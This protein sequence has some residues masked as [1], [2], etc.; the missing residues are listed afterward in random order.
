MNFSYAWDKAYGTARVA[1]LDQEVNN[2]TL[3]S[4]EFGSRIRHH[5][6]GHFGD[7]AQ[8]SNGVYPFFS[9]TYNAPNIVKSFLNGGTLQSINSLHPRNNM[10]GDMV[11]SLLGSK[12]NNGIGMASTCRECSLAYYAAN[13]TT[14]VPSHPNEWE[15]QTILNKHHYKALRAS[16]FTGNQIINKSGYF[17]ANNLRGTT[18]Y[19]KCSNQVSDYYGNKQ[20]LCQMLQYAKDF[21]VIFVAS[22]GNGNT[23]SANWPAN[24]KD[25]VIGVGGTDRTAKTW[26]VYR[27]Q[28]TCPQQTSTNIFNGITINLSVNYLECGSQGNHHSIMAPAKDV[29]VYHHNGSYSITPDLINPNKFVN[30]GTGCI[31]LSTTDPGYQTCSG[32][33]FSAPIITGIISIMRSLNP[34]LSFDE[35]RDILENSR[36]Y[37]SDIG[38]RYSIPNI[39]AIMKNDVLGLVGGNRVLNRL[40]PM[41]RLNT[42]FS[43]SGSMKSNYLSTSI[44]QVAAAGMYGNYLAD[45][46]ELTGSLISG[47]NTYNVDANEPLA[48]GYPKFREPNAAIKPNNARAPFYIFGGHEN[49]F[50]G[51][52]DMIPLHHFALKPV[53]S[54]QPQCYDRADHAYGTVK[55]T[56]FGN[57]DIRCNTDDTRYVW[58]GIEGYLLPSCPTGQTCYENSGDADAAQCLMLRYSSADDSYALLMESEL[59]KAKFNTYTGTVDHLTGMSDAECLGYVYPNVDSDNDLIIDGMELVLG[60]NPND[61]DSD[62]DGYTDGEEYPPTSP[63]VSDPLN[64]NSY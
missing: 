3:N 50:T 35:V 18:S 56:A 53:L 7:F 11:L 47:V 28:G 49:P 60:T 34:L 55:V 43:H 15:R 21:D 27:D 8:S 40:K 26:D 1:I 37:T 51:M 32:T 25:M 57:P 12:A 5:N 54:N 4:S 52:D 17:G 41:F 9:T 46:N 63:I 31:D 30:S 48:V 10:H 59:N 42:R 62:N 61:A 20:P 13:P 22:N 6:V 14:I 2:N 24:E 29:M 45:V 33:S 16:I 58:E 39:S 23:N 38:E 64:A 19:P 44:P 36:V